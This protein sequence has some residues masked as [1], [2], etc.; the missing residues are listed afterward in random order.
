MLPTLMLACAP[1]EP[2]SPTEPTPTG[3]TGEPLPP[4]APPTVRHQLCL[5]GAGADE[6][7]GNPFVTALCEGLP[8]VLRNE[9]DPFFRTW[10]LRLAREAMLEVLDTDGDGAVTDADEAVVDVLGYSW[11]GVNATLIDLHAE[12]GV[13]S[14]R[15]LIGRMALIDPF[16]PPADEPLVLAGRVE[17]LWSYRHTVAPPWDCSAEAFA[18]PYIGRPMDCSSIDGPCVE[19]DVSADRTVSHCSIVSEVAPYVRAN[20]VDGTS[21]APAVWVLP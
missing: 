6:D 1:V 3:D 9:G 16:V 10:E 12:P 11:G 7:G 8:N 13:T 19:H 15:P 2:R 5:N 14:R 20:L 21:T 4:P 17:A 18:G